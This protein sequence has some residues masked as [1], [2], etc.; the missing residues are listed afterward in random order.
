MRKRTLQQKFKME[1]T[2]SIKLGTQADRKEAPNKAL[3]QTFCTHQNQQ[4]RGPN[5]CISAAHRE[6]QRKPT[7]NLAV[8]FRKKQIQKK[9]TP[10]RRSDCYITG[11]DTEIPL[12]EKHR[13]MQKAEQGEKQNT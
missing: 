2:W 6:N 12:P 11:A 4:D 13:K 8:V 1:A 7:D 9:S 5:I 10:E 3:K